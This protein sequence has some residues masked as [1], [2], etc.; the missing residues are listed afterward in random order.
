MWPVSEEGA[1][2]ADRVQR[3]REA[4]WDRYAPEQYD[5]DL[6]ALNDALDTATRVRVDGELMAHIFP[7]IEGKL[8][9]RDA[10]QLVAAAFR[11]AGFEVEE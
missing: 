11:A 2:R 10:E 4:F 9:L 8:G 6:P 7:L 1:A 5:G 3:A